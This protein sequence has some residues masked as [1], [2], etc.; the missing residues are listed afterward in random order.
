VEPQP[1]APVSSFGG[2]VPTRTPY[3]DMSRASVPS[4]EGG[5]EPLASNKTEP[6]PESGP[7]KEKSP[8]FLPFSE[9]MHFMHFIQSISPR[10]E[11]PPVSVGE[12]VHL[13]D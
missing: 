1:I 7:G 5:G 10:F 13:M 11:P 3:K 6:S 4:L 12:L 2:T 9:K 8:N